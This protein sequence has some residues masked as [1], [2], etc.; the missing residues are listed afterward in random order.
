MALPFRERVPPL[1]AGSLS[2]PGQLLAPR[3]EWLFGHQLL[4]K[5]LR[6]DLVGSLAVEHTAQCVPV[7]V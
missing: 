6:E 2:P 3:S 1:A 4:G 5:G 7:N